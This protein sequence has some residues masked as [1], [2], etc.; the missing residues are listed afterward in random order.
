VNGPV[1]LALMILPVRLSL[2][3]APVSLPV[4]GRLCFA[5]VGRCCTVFDGAKDQGDVHMGGHFYKPQLAAST[6]APAPVNLSSSL[7]PD[8]WGCSMSLR[9]RGYPWWW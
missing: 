6:V 7:V 9:K 5:V 4:E 3:S 2:T 8:C 1:A